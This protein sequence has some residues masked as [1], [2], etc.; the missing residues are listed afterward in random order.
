[1]RLRYAV[2]AS[3]LADVLDILDLEFTRGDN[4]APLAM[5]GFDSVV[6]DDAVQRQHPKLGSMLGC[7]YPSYSTTRSSE[8][9][10]GDGPA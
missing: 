4:P 5:G 7:A 10:W 1:M 6:V 9:S 3:C 8:A 2:H